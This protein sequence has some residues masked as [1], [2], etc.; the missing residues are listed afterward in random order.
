MNRTL[1]EQ[2]ALDYCCT[3]EEVQGTDNVFT[4]FRL[5][6]G[7][8][9]WRND[10]DRPFCMCAVGGK[11]LFTGR[12]DIISRV[13]EEYRD[14][15]SEWSFEFGELKELEG[16]L[17]EF[18]CRIKMAHPFFISEKQS[19]VGDAGYEI[20]IYRDGEIE[21]FRGDER[22][23]EAFCFAEDAPDM[24][25]AAAVIDGEIAGMAGA[26][27]D[28]PTMWQIGINVLPEHRGKGIAIR[29]VTEVKNIILSEGRLP[30]YG[31]SLSHLASQRVALSSGFLPAWAELTAER[32]P[33]VT[34]QGK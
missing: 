30:F 13:R 18:G 8:R 19:T 17:G 3:P 24:I 23:D 14:K 1:A 22:W 2:L 21:Q 4:V 33:D 5:L 29:L 20:R 12:E 28:S 34:E 11:R 7:R 27:A 10:G 26:S 31:T 15:G 25:G 6:D 16:I 32:I 9:R